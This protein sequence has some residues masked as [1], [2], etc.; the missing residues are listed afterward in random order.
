M[1]TANPT[2]VFWVGTPGQP[3][4]RHFKP[5]VGL[6]D[7]VAQLVFRGLSQHQAE[8]T[9]SAALDKPYTVTE[10]GVE[11]HFRPVTETQNGIEIHLK[12]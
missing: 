1:T 11:V 7:L 8:F 5:A 3:F 12:A 10:N 6:D 2:P 9:A 4:P